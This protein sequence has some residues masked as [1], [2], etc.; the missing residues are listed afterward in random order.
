MRVRVRVSG[1]VRLLLLCG[2]IAELGLTP[3]VQAT[4]ARAAAASAPRGGTRGPGSRW[5]GR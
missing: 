2:L 3:V 1:L 5:P 4:P